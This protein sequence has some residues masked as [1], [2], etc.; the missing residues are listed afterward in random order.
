MSFDAFFVRQPINILIISFI[1]WVLFSACLNS[2]QIVLLALAAWGGIEGS[3]C[4][5]FSF[6]GAPKL[7]HLQ[8]KPVQEGLISIPGGQCQC[9]RHRTPRGVNQAVII[10]N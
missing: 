5:P 9:C 7:V 6:D 1:E 8:I 3:G 4:A 2:C 10:A